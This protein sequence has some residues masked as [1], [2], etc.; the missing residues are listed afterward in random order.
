VIT[1]H[2]L[3]D[4]VVKRFLRVRSKSFSNASGPLG[5]HRFVPPLLAHPPKSIT[6]GAAER[7][8]NPRARSARLRVGARRA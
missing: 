7:A 6:P 5:V 3:E 4:R 2:S 8:R 1:F